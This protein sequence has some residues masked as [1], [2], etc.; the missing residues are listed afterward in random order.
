[1]GGEG[2]RR[3]VEI[4]PLVDGEE[5][6]DAAAVVKV[7]VGEDHGVHLGQG[8]AHL[9]RV[10]NKQ[11][12]LPHVEEQAVPGRGDVQAQPVLGRKA[13]PGGV[14]DENVEGDHAW[15]SRPTQS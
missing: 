8:Q 12:V 5:I 1:M 9:A 10:G 11:A 14:L 15:C 4:G 7:P 3:G 2:P 6:G 13:R